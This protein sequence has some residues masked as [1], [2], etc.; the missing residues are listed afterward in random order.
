MSYTIRYSDPSK[1]N[2]PIIVQDGTSYNSVGTGGL[3]L[4]GRNFPGYG[5]AVAENLIHILENSASPVPPINPIEGQLWFDISDPTNKK[6]R[7]NDGAANVTQWKP[8]NGIF[9]QANEPSNA[10]VGDIWVDTNEE[11]VKFYTAAGVFE[12]VGKQITASGTGVEALTV[13]DSSQQPKTVLVQKVEDEI[14]AVL[15]ADTFQTGD[16][17]G[18]T[19]INVGINLP[20][21]PIQ[22]PENGFINPKLHGVA[23]RAE[24]LIL[25]NGALIAANVVLRNDTNQ[26]IAGQF[27]INQDLNALRIGTNPTFI[28]DKPTATSLDVNFTN[29]AGTLGTFNFLI[30]SAIGSA[31][32]ALTIGGSNKEVRVRSNYESNSTI[33]GALQVLG[34][35]GIGGNAYIGG[36]IY[37]NSMY[38][39]DGNY[40]SNGQILVTENNKVYWRSFNPSAF[41][42]GG[43]SSGVFTITNVTES[44]STTSGALQVAG[45]AGIGQ[46][47]TVGGNVRVLATTSATST[48]TGALTVAGGVGIRGDLRV[49]GDIYSSKLIIDET[50]INSTVVQTGDVI[51]A[52]S[53]LNATSTVTGALRVTGGVGVG[54]DL[55]V[56][57][58]IN[59]TSITATVSGVAT[60]ATNLVGGTTGS[61]PVQT[62][63][64]ITSFISP[65]TADQ[66]LRS[67]GST[68]AFV[69]TATMYVNSAV[70]AERFRT[71]R[72]ITFTGDV[73]GTF[74]LDGTQATGTAL[75]IQPNSIALGVDT[76]GDYISTGTTS[77][78]GISGS[79]SG[80]GTTFNINSNATSTNDVS[81]IVFRNSLGSFAGN[82]ITANIFSGSAQQLTNIPG[83]QIDIGSVRNTSLTSSS[84]GFAAGTGI[85]LS[86]SSVDLGNSVTIT[87][88]GVTALTGSAFLA[89]S[90]ATGSITLTNNGVHSLTAGAGIVL[91]AS[92]GSITISSSALT[93]TQATTYIGISTT[94]GVAT[95][96]N[97][98][99]Q[100]IT[101]ADSIAVST[102]TGTVTISNNGVRSITGSP[103]LAVSAST[104][105]VTITNNGVQTLTGSAFL[106]VSASTGT[107]TITNNGVHSIAVN[108]A[109]GVNASTG[110]ITI[111]DLGVQ[112][113]VGSSHLAVDQSTGTV[114]ITNNGVR[115]I[116]GSPY[117]AVSASTGT[118]TITNNGVQTLTGSSHLAVSAS[119]GTITISNNGVRSVSVVGALGV[120]QS[121][122]TITITDLGVRAI[123]GSPYIGVDQSTGTVVIANNGV[124][125]LSAGTDTSVSAST[126]TVTVWNNST[127]QTITS[128]GSAS[129]N[130]I[131]ITNATAAS[132]VNTGALVVSGGTAVGGDLR[133][134]QSVF[135]T[136]NQTIT[137][138]LT[139]D[140]VSQKLGSSVAT[141]LVDIGYGAT[142]SGN[143]KTINIGT[144]GLAGSTVLVNIGSDA[145]SISSSTVN[146]DLIVT[147]SLFMQGAVV[148]ASIATATVATFTGTPTGATFYFTDIVPPKMGIYGSS[149]WRDAVGN[150]LF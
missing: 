20:T 7:I 145:A 102:S 88:S 53:I 6:L 29:D 113:I 19:N 58:S 106:A 123:L 30:K 39:A 129:S 70:Q 117:L 2:F 130:A 92:T 100:T 42:T 13:E 14:V 146:G 139:L 142:T 79:I 75:T 108:G 1:A 90:T 87:N 82:V 144:G 140:G 85:S 125:T 91:S 115:S 63:A 49:G 74:V 109:L 3:T 133:V 27:T 134:G 34:G 68:A 66:F 78:Y 81:T 31:F 147:S 10:A 60:S 18:F 101:G 121:T 23:T 17:L 56:G 148:L 65:G 43:S 32:N 61:I 110:T 107:V 36:S 12:P 143:T 21:D 118:I 71:P 83:I 50:V 47:L 59:A 77:G 127:L 114:T 98:G 138:T 62:A 80:E 67:S 69:S 35:V 51:S 96:T 52:T 37:A 132:S 24:N 137:G 116:T 84:I 25:N 95:F 4:V 93:N 73:T 28:I 99:V 126:G 135:V 122:G 40:G 119:T 15:S 76:V 105:T 16:L 26:S 22:T 94:N 149:A 97:L 11:L 41:A 46:N 136:S 124:Q 44:L 55:W 54:L 64:G 128:R 45:G 104:G 72:T 120:D 131:Q 150:I 5:Q 38:D 33:T 8:I 111:T 89:V 86:T 112:S 103:Y 141:S 48:T 9:Q 57:G